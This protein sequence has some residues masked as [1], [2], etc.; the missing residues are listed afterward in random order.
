[1][2]YGLVDLMDE[3]RAAAAHVHVPY[4]MLH[5]LGDRLI[6]QAPVKAA[7]EEMPRRPDSRLAFYKDGYHLL[8]RDKD[9]KRVA[10]DVAAW[11]LDRDAPL[12]SGADAERSNPALAALW[13]RKRPAVSRP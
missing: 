5:G 9:G 13:G 11:I 10:N 4:L 7:I 2:G 6:P 12:P 3:A 1:M 8:L